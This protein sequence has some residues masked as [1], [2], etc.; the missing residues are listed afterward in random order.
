M[1]FPDYPRKGESPRDTII[2]ILNWM[3]A[4]RVVGCVG[5]RVIENPGGTTIVPPQPTPQRATALNDAP[6]SVSVGTSEDGE[7]YYATVT[8]GLVIERKQGK[9]ADLVVGHEPTN[10]TDA[11]G[12]PSKI[13][14]KDGDGVFVVVKLTADG[15]VETGGVSIKA[16]P[17]DGIEMTHYTP[18][19]ADDEGATGE[20]KY[21]LGRFSVSKESGQKWENDFA[22]S[23]IDHF[24]DLPPFKKQAGDNDVFKKYDLDE[25]CYK[26]KGLT[27]WL[28]DY[29]GAIKSIKIDDTGDELRFRTNGKDLDLQVYEFFMNTDGNL[30]QATAPSEVLCIRDGIYIG[31]FSD[32]SVPG[33]N[34]TVVKSRISR[35]RA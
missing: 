10:L 4:S 31:S 17:H 9:E 24:Q 18:K 14:I 21:R 23:H 6:F 34:G 27:E 15:E 35:L 3:R 26:T 19:V 29:T 33:A 13:S 7:T 28:P 8:K 25:K 12:N 30:E 2:Q 1:K 20:M 11:E 22:G 5:G 32:S 16:E